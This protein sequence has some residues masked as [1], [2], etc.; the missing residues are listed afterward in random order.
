MRV[1]REARQAKGQAGQERGPGGIPAGQLAL[2]DQV[3]H[4]LRSRS[5]TASSQTGN[6]VEAELGQ[7][8]AEP[9]HVEVGLAG[10]QVGV[11][12]RTGREHAKCGQSK[13]GQG[14]NTG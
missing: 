14:G 8:E 4:M 9:D 12:V 3:R 6:H 7:V 5:Y 1:G 11:R 10:R 13:R 2:Y